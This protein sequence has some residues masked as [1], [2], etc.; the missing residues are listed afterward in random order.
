MEGC[1]R[2]KEIPENNQARLGYE[3]DRVKIPEEIY[4]DAHGVYRWSYSFHM[5]KNPVILFTVWKV[6]AIAVGITSLIVLAISGI[7][8]SVRNWESVLNLTIG[9]A[10][11]LIGFLFLGLIAYLILANI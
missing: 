3:T 1:Q 4:R 11:F 8:G 6:L 5:L 10:A 9:F 7:D 2:R